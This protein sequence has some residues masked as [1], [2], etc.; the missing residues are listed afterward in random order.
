MTSTPHSESAQTITNSNTKDLKQ[1]EKIEHSQEQAN[2]TNSPTVHQE[3]EQF[4]WREVIRGI[5][6][7]YSFFISNYSLSMRHKGITDV[8]TWLTGLAYFGLLVSLYSYSL[9]LCVPVLV[10]MSMGDP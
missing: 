3:D 6:P 4:E 5:N 8:Q 2:L 9:F 10:A 7:C 1:D